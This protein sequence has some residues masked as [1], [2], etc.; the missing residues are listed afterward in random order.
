MYNLRHLRNY[1]AHVAVAATAL[2]LI[3]CGDSGTKLDT[4]VSGIVRAEI[5]QKYPADKEI[6][7]D[8]IVKEGSE[9]GEKGKP[10]LL[11]VP[12]RAS[13]VYGNMLREECREMEYSV[14]GY[15]LLRIECDLEGRVIGIDDTGRY[16]VG[17]VTKVTKY[18][19]GKRLEGAKEKSKELGEKAV[20]KGKSGLGYAAEWTRKRMEELEKWLKSK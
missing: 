2:S 19:A 4:S 7:L 16:H 14:F 5:K 17:E 9:V 6:I 15:G 8:I 3:G 1:V 12:N 13:G 20:E 10:A 18:D 11:L